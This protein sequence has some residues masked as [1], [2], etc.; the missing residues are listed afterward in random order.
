[1]AI[2]LKMRLCL[3]ESKLPVN[4]KAVRFTY[5]ELQCRKINSPVL[6]QDA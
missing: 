5:S 4:I 6:V 2:F 1:M 3:G